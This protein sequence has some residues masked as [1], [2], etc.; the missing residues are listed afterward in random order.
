M[1]LLTR[2]TH[3]LDLSDPLTAQISPSFTAHV[4][5]KAGEYAGIPEYIFYDSSEGAL[6]DAQKKTFQLL[7]DGASYAV[8]D[9]KGKVLVYRRQ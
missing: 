7:T 4:L 2:K 9:R 5:E 3:L 6:Q 8:I 1:L